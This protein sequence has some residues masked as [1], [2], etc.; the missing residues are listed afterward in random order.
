MCVYLH[1]LLYLFCARFVPFG[2]WNTQTLQV[3]LR[4][5]ETATVLSMQ[6]IKESSSLLQG[7]EARQA[8]LDWLEL[9]HE[10]HPTSRCG[11]CSHSSS[12]PAVL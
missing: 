2:P 10:A 4:D 6:Y 7:A 1:V 8:L 5:V 12:H 3:D 11:V 9:L